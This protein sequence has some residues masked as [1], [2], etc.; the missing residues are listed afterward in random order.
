MWVDY[1]VPIY[2][3]NWKISSGHHF[4]NGWIL[5]ISDNV[6]FLPSIFYAVIWQPF[7][8]FWKCRIAPLMVTYH[9]R[10]NSTLSDFNDISYVGRLW[11]PEFIPDIE[12]FLAVAIFK[13]AAKIQ[14]CLISKF[15]MWVDHN[16]PTYEMSL[17]SDNVEFVWYCDGHIEN[18]DQ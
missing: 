15:D 10:T 9:Y 14:H 17:K 16:L 2:S 4:Q 1:D 13:M 18:G 7:W 11:C 8:K 3:R 12:N 5:M 6:E